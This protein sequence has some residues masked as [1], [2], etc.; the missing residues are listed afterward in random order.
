MRSYAM[1]ADPLRWCRSL[2]CF[3]C[4]ELCLVWMSH[5]VRNWA[6]FVRAYTDNNKSSSSSSSSNKRA[7]ERKPGM[8]KTIADTAGLA[9]WLEY[10]LWWKSGKELVFSTQWES[11]LWIR[12]LTRRCRCWWNKNSIREHTQHI[13]KANNRDFSLLEIEGNFFPLK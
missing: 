10:T 6:P 3:R 12:D 13:T 7:K 2:A 1:L 5:A 11:D 4:Y 8:M 9:D